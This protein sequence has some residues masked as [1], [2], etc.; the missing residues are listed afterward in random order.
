MPAYRDEDKGNWFVSFYYQDWKGKRV[1]KLKRGFKTKK[2]AQ[3]W[4]NN[5]KLQSENNLDMKF[6][7]FVSM[8]KSDIK[9]RV[10]YNTWISKEYIINLKIIPAFGERKINEI[11]PSDII[12][13]QNELIGYRNDRGEGFS[14]TYLKA[15]HNQLTAIFNHAVRFYDLKSNPA[16]TVGCMGSKKSDKE[17]LVWTKE[18]YIKF[19]DSMMDKDISFHAFEILY[20]CGI[21]VGELLALTPSDF[22]FEEGTVSI[23]KSYQRIKG[24]DIITTPK[25]EK[26]KRIIN[27]PDFLVDEMQDYISRL[28]GCKPKSRIFPITKAVLYSEMKRGATEQNIKKIRI[29][30]LRHSHVSLLIDMGFSAVAIADRV[31]HESIDITYHYA[32]L[33]PTKQNEIANSLNNLKEGI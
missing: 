12:Q 25:T 1:K 2:E 3:E 29:H 32:H 4:E 18:E 24:E 6:K 10:K 5:F 15:I 19:S 17:M 16:R 13:W 21:R 27:M 33:F 8:Y 31:G 23:T 30:D 7:D 14:P 28:Y 11:K 22:N 20:W 26:G 9:T